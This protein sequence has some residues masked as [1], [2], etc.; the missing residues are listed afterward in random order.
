[1]V[2]NHH[3][4]IAANTSWYVHNFRGRLIRELRDRGYR[5]T[6]YS[7]ADDY[8]PKLCDLGANH[9]PLSMDNAG[10][11]P[12]FE[13]LSLARITTVLYRLRPD[14]LLTYTPKVNIYISLAAC[15]LRIPV[16]ANVSGLGQAFVARGW[17]QTVAR[18]LYGVALRTP[19]LVFFQNDTDQAEFIAS[20][21]VQPGRTDRLP[22]SGVDVNHFRPIENRISR[23]SPFC[24]L[25]SAR[26][27]WDKGVAEYVDAARMVRA[28][29]PDTKFLLLGFLDSQNPRAVP[30]SIL[31]QWMQEG[32]VEYLGAVDD[33]RPVYG[34]ADC[35][36]LPSYY[37]EGVPRA[38]LEAASME[39]PVITTNTAGCRDAVDDRIT[40][41]L[42]RP[43]DARDLANAMAAMISLSPADRRE[44]G[45]AGREKMLRTFDERFVL[46][47]YLNA[48]DQLMQQALDRQSPSTTPAS[49]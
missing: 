35:V 42:C 18:A 23:P 8:V 27:L 5:V 31:S 22:G 41:L 37:R 30:R 1:M 36:V 17:L 34:S 39:I 2:K 16:I 24:F 9:V 32:V 6:V 26:M 3:V 48:I 21:L 19:H 4:C 45:R 49:R 47:K 38:L 43:R 33:V 40:G 44:M 12:L 25:L 29:Y 14:L 10:T 11:N 15:L 20:R 28:M 7:P 46:L 13:T